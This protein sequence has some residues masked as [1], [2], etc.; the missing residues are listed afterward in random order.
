MF[1]QISAWDDCVISME[2]LTPGMFS[3]NNPYGACPT[4]TVLGF[5]YEIDP[6]RIIPI[7]IY[8]SE[9]GL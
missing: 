7:K 6:E 8:L 1:S 9:E 3:F 2:D 5:K 4:C